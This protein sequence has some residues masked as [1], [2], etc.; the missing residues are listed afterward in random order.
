MRVDQVQNNIR[1]T[2]TQVSCCSSTT[3]YVSDLYYSFLGR[4]P[5][6]DPNNPSTGWGFW[7]QNTNNNG[8]Q[9]TLNAFK[10]AGDF[11][12]LVG[13]LC[14]NVSGGS[15]PT[16]V[17][18]LP[19]LSFDSTTNRITTAGFE[20]DASGN[21]TKIARTDGSIQQLQYDAAG[22]LSNVK[23]A[24]NNPLATYTYGIGNDRLIVQEG[25]LRTYYASDGGSTLAEYTDVV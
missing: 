14:P 4:A 6:G 19:N 8:R 20:Y 16:P 3:D 2:K 1:V 17:D 13:T 23:D 18:G 10:A 7:V 5:D 25:S 12:N 11:S 24:S 21:Q 22:R 9:A 15:S